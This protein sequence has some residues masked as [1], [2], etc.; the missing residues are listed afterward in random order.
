MRRLRFTR[1][2]KPRSGHLRAAF[3]LTVALLPF[4]IVF[5]L[6]WIAPKI[7]LLSR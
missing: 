7:A 5:V 4:F 2:N 3:W 6:F 1:E